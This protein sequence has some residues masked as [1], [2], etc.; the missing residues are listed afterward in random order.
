MSTSGVVNDS[1]LTFGILPNA[2]HYGENP[3]SFYTGSFPV[4]QGIS[5]STVVSA[6]L[7]SY[8]ST[9]GYDDRGYIKSYVESD[10]HILTTHNLSIDDSSSTDFYFDFEVYYINAAIGI[11]PYLF[12]MYENGNYKL[13]GRI[14]EDTRYPE[15][16]CKLH[17]SDTQVVVRAAVPIPLYEFTRVGFRKSGAEFSI[18]LNGVEVSAYDSTGSIGSIYSYTF[19]EPISVGNP[20]NIGGE[21]WYGRIYE[22]L[23]FD[24][25]ALTSADILDINDSMGSNA[26][27]SLYGYDNGDSTM[28]LVFSATGEGRTVDTT[29]YWT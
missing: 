22:A 20:P 2:Y 7:V 8:G 4:Y 23:F 11:D 3:A 12:S 25:S 24:G 5:A 1:R 27:G 26:F 15:I 28:S 17:A 21:A 10:A 29:I 19:T 13:F 14:R 6:T 18:Y 16:T 9:F